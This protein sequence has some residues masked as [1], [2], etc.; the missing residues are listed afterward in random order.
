MGQSGDCPREGGFLLGDTGSS[1]TSESMMS[2]KSFSMELTRELWLGSRAGSWRL[3]FTRAS[4]FAGS[5][6]RAAGLL[7]PA[8]IML[9]IHLASAGW[10]KRRK[11]A[12][13]RQMVH[14]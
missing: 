10:L 4:G 13:P 5:P 11:V 3:P 7:P 8:G 2:C 6:Y 1:S 12:W 9:F 14:P